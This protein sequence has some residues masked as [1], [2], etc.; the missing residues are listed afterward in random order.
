MAG[1]KELKNLSLSVEASKGEILL[2]LKANPS[3]LLVDKLHFSNIIYNLLDNAIKY[4][5]KPPRI[6][7]TTR[8]RDRGRLEFCVSDNGIG[9]SAEN[10]QK[11]FHKFFRVPTGNVHDVKGFGLGLNYVKAMVEK[12]GGKIT[13]KSTLGV[14]TTFSIVLPLHLNENPHE[15][16]DSPRGR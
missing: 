4:N 12:H 7:L 13:I 10:Q 14:G 9:I 8:I 6:M 16:T 11:I 15:R 2:D 3:R 1:L 5:Q